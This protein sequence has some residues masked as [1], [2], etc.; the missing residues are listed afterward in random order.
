MLN[1]TPF[2]WISK[3]QKTVETSTYGSDLVVSRISMELI[4]EIRYMFRSLRMALD[5]PALMLVDNMSVFLNTTFPP[6]ILKKKHNCISLGKRSYFSKD[7]EVS[8][9]QE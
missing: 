7:D 3:S 9:H 5:G 6:S 8:I 1:N 2:R 4:L